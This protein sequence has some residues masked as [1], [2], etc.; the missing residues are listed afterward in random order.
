MDAKER[1]KYLLE[2]FG[3][4]QASENEREELF[5]L[6]E[7]EKD[8]ALKQQLYHVIQSYT[9]EENPALV[10][11]GKLFTYIQEEKHNRNQQEVIPLRNRRYSH[12]KWS[13]AAAIILC[14]FG[15]GIYILSHREITANLTTQNQMVKLSDI[16]PPDASNAIL[17]LNNGKKILL[18]SLNIGQSVKNGTVRIQRREDG[19]LT[20]QGTEDGALMNTLVNPK[21]SKVLAL[22]LNDGTNLWLNAASSISFPT[23]FDADK[24]QVL[25]DGEAYFEVKHDAHKPFIVKK[26]DMRVQ[27]L[28]THFNVNAYSNENA[29]KV[30]LLQGSVNIKSGS[31]ETLIEPGQQANV[32]KRAGNP[33]HV[34]KHINVDEVIAWQNGKFI[35]KNQDIHTIMRQVARWYNV[36]IEFKDEI[37]EKFYADLSRTTSITTLLKMLEATNAVHFKLKNKTIIVMKGNKYPLNGLR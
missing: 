9:E 15:V 19:K 7:Q 16:S 28:G 13:A 12:L 30:T 24:R 36:D 6:I 37:H 14:F 25:L 17:T 11:W 3:S 23:S 35:F 34:I 1:L 26:G 29:I 4:R 22:V 20:I 8:R 27:V 21:G 33:I 10:N 18:D 31:S 5:Q 2:V 32:D